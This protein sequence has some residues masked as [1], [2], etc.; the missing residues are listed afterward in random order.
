MSAMSIL[1]FCNMAKSSSLC[2]ARPFA[3]QFRM[4]RERD[5]ALLFGIFSV[6]EICEDGGEERDERVYYRFELVQEF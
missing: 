3:F 4:R 1:L 2:F 5:V 6:N